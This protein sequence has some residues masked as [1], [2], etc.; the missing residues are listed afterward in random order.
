MSIR[1][2]IEPEW[3]RDSF[4][5]H[6]LEK[7][8]NGRMFSARP[9]ELVMDEVS[10]YRPGGE[11]NTPPFLRVDAFLGQGEFFA[12]LA[13]ELARLGFRDSKDEEQAKDVLKA[14]E[15]HL[16]DLRKLVFKAD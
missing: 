11:L 9:A 16:Q 2:H 3:G 10:E 5:V 6:V 8:S 15:D 12:A 14:K 1:V 4:A 7:L 13:K